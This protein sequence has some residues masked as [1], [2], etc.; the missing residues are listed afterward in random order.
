MEKYYGV[1][2]YVYCSAS[3]LNIVDI[4]GK[5]GILIVFPDY[6]ITV[7]ENRYSH[8]GHAGILLINPDDG[9]TKYYEYGRYDD[10][11]K[12]LVRNYS[13]PNVI[14]GEDGLPTKESLNKVLDVI[15]EKSG[16]GGRIEG[17]YIRSRNY[18]SML[19]YAEKRMDDNKN[20]NRK[21]YSV[22]FNNC[23]TFA[24]EVLDQDLWSQFR[25]PVLRSPIPAVRVKQYHVLFP[26]VSYSPQKR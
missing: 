12:G 9:Y 15:S 22:L 8:L 19:E 18:D 14:M 25:S 2:P 16:H 23:V 17:A 10:E 20:P 26:R 5:D 13:I 7:G 1:S 4:D 11:N 6:V 24:S 21:P 3:P